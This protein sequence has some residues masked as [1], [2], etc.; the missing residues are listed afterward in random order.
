MDGTSTS[1]STD[2]Q[3]YVFFIFSLFKALLNTFL[4]KYVSVCMTASAGLEIP[5]LCQLGQGGSVTCNHVYVYS[6]TKY[7]YGFF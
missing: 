7:N 4:H 1:Q 5:E 6:F 3:R 2:T